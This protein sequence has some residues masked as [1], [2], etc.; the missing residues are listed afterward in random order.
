MS[1]SPQG[2]HIY[3]YGYTE[4]NW[5][6]YS[7]KSKTTKNLTSKLNV[8]FF[9]EEN[10]YPTD[11]YP[12]GISGWIKDD[13]YILIRDRYDIWKIDPTMKQT[14]MNLTNHYGRKNNIR[15]AAVDLNPD[16]DFIDP[17][18]EI[19]LRAFNYSNKQSGYYKT[20]LNSKSD[21]N[22]ILVDDYLDSRRPVKAKNA[23]RIIWQKQSFK[24]Y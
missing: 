9:D 5:F 4:K 8:N 21:P 10:D 22:K 14:P 19:L 17:T 13:K 1:I 24:E 23:D 3:W 16:L 7:I 11:A 18:E 12:Y 6:A 15:F 20:N 2:N